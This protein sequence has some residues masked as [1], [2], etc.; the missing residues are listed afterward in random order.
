MKKLIFILAISVGT[1]ITAQVQ[2]SV[3]SKKLYVKANAVFI[4]VG[5]LNA[6]LE[7]QL[8][9]KIT[10]QG[11]VFISPWK[12]FLGKY[13]QM[14]MG[15]VEG[16]YYFKEAFSK[17]YVGVNIGA[18]VFKMQ[19][20]NYWSDAPFQYTETSPIYVTSDL[21]QRGFSL[22]MG[23]TVGYQF[24][25]NENWNVDV[26]AGGGTSQG[27]YR[28]YHK[29]LGVRYDEDGRTW[30]KSGEWIPYRGGIMISYKL[31]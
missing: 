21:Y 28:G 17:W 11:D 3:T 10:L 18:S 16:R 15:F 6:G 30:N 13:A 20:W 24:H 8:S 26:F 25:I 7:Y 5:M 14:Y 2:D 23:A 4:P 19:K 27:F 9:P 31:K 12:S 22:M 1:F 29:I